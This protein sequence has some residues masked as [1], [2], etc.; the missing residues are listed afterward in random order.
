MATRNLRRAAP[1]IAQ[2]TC[3]SVM[4]RKSH[5]PTLDNAPLSTQLALPKSVYLAHHVTNKPGRRF[6]INDDDFDPNT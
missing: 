2:Q 6:V 1:P 5:H 4:A 3:P